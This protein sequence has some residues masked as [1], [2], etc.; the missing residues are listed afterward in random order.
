MA[1]RLKGGIIEDSLATKATEYRGL[2]CHW[3][4]VIF[5]VPA[6]APWVNYLITFTHQSTTTQEDHEHNEGLKPVVLN[7]SEA[8]STQVPPLFSSPFLH[9]NLTALESPYTACKHKVPIGVEK[10]ALPP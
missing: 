6:V 4:Q 10:T 5:R 8:S 1:G 2:K 7:Y 9:A 3:C